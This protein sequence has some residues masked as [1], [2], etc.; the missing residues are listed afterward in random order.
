MNIIKF[1]SARF[2][3]IQCRHDFLTEKLL[4]RSIIRIKTPDSGGN[5]L[6]YASV[7]PLSK[8][9]LF[10]TSKTE[11][12]VTADVVSKIA[13]ANE[14]GSTSIAGKTYYVSYDALYF[15]T[16]NKIKIN[17]K[18]RRDKGKTRFPHFPQSLL[19]LLLPNI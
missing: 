14:D 12:N 9:A 7:N 6:A 19:L 11:Y 13:S 4:V 1:K 10:D 8:I 3:E 17:E 18:A 16:D 2:T 15:N 5:F